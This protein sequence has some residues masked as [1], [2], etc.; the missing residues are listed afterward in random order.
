MPTILSISDIIEIGDVSTYK[1]ANYTSKKLLFG[2]SIIKPQ[3]PVQI[4]YIT[5][6]LRWAVDGG[7]ES[8]AN[9]RAM[10]NYLYWLCGLFQ[11]EA[12]AI[13]NGAGGGSVVPTPSSAS[14]PNPYDFEVAASTSSSAPLADGESSVTLDGTNG[15]RDYRGFNL[16][17]NRGGIPQSTTTALGS[18]YTWNRTTGQFTCTPAATLSEVFQLIPI[19]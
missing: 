14:L 10:A 16:A 18:Y 13:I 5:D 3:P 4:A 7:A 15:T 19:G 9:N 6:A 1:S 12:Q 8:D 17:F 11:L 2:G